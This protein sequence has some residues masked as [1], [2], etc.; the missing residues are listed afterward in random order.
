MKLRPYTGAEI[1]RISDA[2]KSGTPIAVIAADANRSI[3]AL[4]CMMERYRDLFPYRALSQGVKLFD[5]SEARAMRDKG[6]S[7]GAIGKAL[8]VTPSAIWTGLR[9]SA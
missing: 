2:W 5:R 4:Y 7:F 6:M 3:T 8:G 9:R 1:R